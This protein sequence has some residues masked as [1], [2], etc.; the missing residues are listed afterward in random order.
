V[1][2]WLSCLLIA[3]L[4]LLQC[5]RRFEAAVDAMIKAGASPARMGPHFKRAFEKP[6]V[7]A[8][9]R[10]YELFVPKERQMWL[11]KIKNRV[12]KGLRSGS[13]SLKL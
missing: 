4:L 9:V 2:R 8:L 7:L 1:H 12:S 11:G 3:L 6:V 13:R 10:D 5:C